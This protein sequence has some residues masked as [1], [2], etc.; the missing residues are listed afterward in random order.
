MDS[1]LILTK[2]GK[3]FAENASDWVWWN[4]AV[5]TKIKADYEAGYKIVIM[6]NQGGVS[7]GMVTSSTLKAKFIQLYKS[8][9]IPFQFFCATTSDEYRKPAT[10]MWKYFI[11]H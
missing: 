7:T 8:L 2:S 3:K 4:Q 6:S 5:P 1:T 11:K 10:G 9:K